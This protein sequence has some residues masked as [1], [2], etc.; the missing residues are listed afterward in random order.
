MISVWLQCLMYPCTGHPCLWFCAFMQDWMESST[1]ATIEIC[2]DFK[3]WGSKTPQKPPPPLGYKCDANPMVTSWYLLPFLMVRGV[4]VGLYID[5]CISATEIFSGWATEAVYNLGLVLILD[6][7][8]PWGQGVWKASQR[9]ALVVIVK[10]KQKRKNKSKNST[11]C[12]FP[13][14]P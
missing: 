6:S 12:L 4:G 8:F 1:T 14:N 2:R 11:A 5:S 9:C 7:R 3:I 13:Q 10:R